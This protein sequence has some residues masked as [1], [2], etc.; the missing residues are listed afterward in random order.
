[1]K[2]PLYRFLVFFSFVSSLLAWV[3]PSAAQITAV[4]ETPSNKQNVS[5]IGVISGWAFSSVPNAKVTVQL[6]VDGNTIGTVACCSERDDV[7]QQYGSQA[8]LSGFAQGENFSNLSNGS[9]KI[10]VAISDNAGSPTKTIEIEISVIKVGGFSVLNVLDISQSTASIS[11][12]EI[13]LAKAFA[14][15]KASLNSQQVKVTLAWQENQ[16]S[17]AIVKSE[18]TDTA[19][20]SSNS[21]KS[22]SSSNALLVEAPRV[23]RAE[24]ASDTIQAAL[25]NPPLLFPTTVSGKGLISGWAFSTTSGV[26]ITKVQVLIDGTPALTIPCCTE[27][28]DVAQ[29]FPD[30]PQAGQSGFAA[31]VNFNEL[32]S[33]THTIQVKIDDSAGTSTTIERDVIAV[34]LGGI[35]FIDDFDL[36]NATA[37]IDAST[38]LSL[39]NVKISG[40]DSTGQSVEKEISADFNWEPSCQ[41][42]VTRSSCGDGSVEPNEECDGSAFPSDLNSCTALGF[43]GGTLGCTSTCFFDTTEC[44]GGKSLYVTNVLSNSVSVVNTATN[45]VTATIPVGRSPRG[46]AIS[47]DGAS[48]Y[49]ANARDNTVSV[50]NTA[51]NTVSLTLPVGNSPQGVTVAPDGSKVYVVNGLSNSVSVLD[52]ATKQTLTTVNVGRQPQALALTPD[53]KFAYVTNYIDN[54]VTVFDTSTNTVVTTITD[55][56]GNGPNGIAVTPD[57]KQAYAVSFNE[58]SV[59]IIDVLTNTIP[60]TPFTIGLQPSRVTFSPSGANAYISSALDFSVFALDTAT[61]EQVA[62]VPTPDQPDGLV[63]APKGKRLYVSIFGRNG[64][65]NQIELISTITNTLVTTNSD[66]NGPSATT[67]TV[68]DGPFGLA[69]TP[70][71]P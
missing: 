19:I 67:I 71:Q 37:T 38:V 9:H 59:S 57:G 43:S 23:A 28:A 3:R 22:V 50:V 64:E 12:Q 63:V 18:N 10:A 46:I 24:T 42:F 52:A 17:L 55:N 20:N 69:L 56:I 53:G 48:L 32:S 34:Q 51:D 33:A 62:A 26:T 6:S 61:L 14:N 7:A 16:Q 39:N 21:L 1:M 49:V 65:G 47:P 45:S 68:G 8:L 66:D 5:G 27:R 4:L 31:G 30:F 44:S 29:A 54:S 11:N 15:E 36:S 70:D 25:E 41:C 60:Q 35:A 58:N 13:V 40:T 2:L